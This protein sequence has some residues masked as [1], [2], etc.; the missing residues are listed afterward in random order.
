MLRRR[1]NKAQKDITI[2]IDNIRGTIY[3]PDNLDIVTGF[4]PQWD[5]DILFSEATK[6]DLVISF[7]HP[8]IDRVIGIS[9]VSKGTTIYHCQ[10]PGIDFATAMKYMYITHENT[11]GKSVTINN[12]KYRVVERVWKDD[13]LHVAIGWQMKVIKY[14]NDK[15]GIELLSG[16]VDDNI[17]GI[18]W[19]ASTDGIVSTKVAQYSYDFKKIE[20]SENIIIGAIKDWISPNYFTKELIE[21]VGLNWVLDSSQSGKIKDSSGIVTDCRIVTSTSISSIKN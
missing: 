15:Y 19:G 9:Y 6:D 8:E 12:N 3:N 14:N 10:V 20:H 7:L 1:F 18:E 5:F 2:T 21:E 17:I 11:H 16:C 4:V 13:D